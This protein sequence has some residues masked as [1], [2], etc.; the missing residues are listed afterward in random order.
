VLEVTAMVVEE[1]SV[2]DVG[3]LALEAT[4]RFLGRLQLDD[5]AVVVLAAGPAVAGLDDGGGV[6]GG[7]ELA[8]PDR[9]SRCRRMSPLEASMGAVPV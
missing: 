3:E 6:E 2:D 7:V 4:L 9:L 5:L 8:I 1:V